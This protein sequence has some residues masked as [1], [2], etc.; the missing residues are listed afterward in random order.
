MRDGLAYQQVSWWEQAKQHKGILFR[1]TEAIELL[2]EVD[3]VAFDKTGT[4]T[5]GKPTLSLFQVLPPFDSSTLLAQLALVEQRSEHPLGIAV[6]EA[7]QEMKLSTTLE[8]VDFHAIAGSGIDARLS[9][10]DRVLIGSEKYLNEQNIDTSIVNQHVD[11]AIEKGSGYFF[12]AIN[13]QLAAL[14]VVSDPLKPSTPLAVARLIKSN[15]DVALISGDNLRTANSI[16]KRCGIRSDMVHAEVRPNEKAAVIQSLKQSRSDSKLRRVAF[17]GDGI[18]DAPALTVADVGIAMGTGTDL[19]IESA[20]VIAM[21]GDIQ[22]IPRA[23]DLARSV[24]V[25]IKQNLAWAFGYNLL[26]IP[27]ATGLLYPWLGLSLSPVVAG[28][29]MSLSS[30]FVV[31]NAL[32]L[33]S[34]KG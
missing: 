32:R 16:A 30:F 15:F 31:T 10:G 26:L 33:R 22:N 3:T 7:A 29:A 5:V 19:A 12:A 25:N 13:R 23:I 2:S 4:L 27:I 24:M 34:W 20:D 21:S 28:L 6:V 9:N 8:V 11:E 17:V 1:S 14:I 18:N